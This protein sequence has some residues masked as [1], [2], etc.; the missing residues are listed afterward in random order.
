MKYT[1]PSGK[2]QH[3]PCLFLK[4]V[5]NWC[6]NLCQ[7]DFNS[8]KDKLPFKCSDQKQNRFTDILLIQP[9]NGENLKVELKG[10]MTIQLHLHLFGN[11]IKK[12]KNLLLIFYRAYML[13]ILL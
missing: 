4:V 6:P 8:I 12:Y 13:H 10:K 9:Y 1:Q 3:F 5:P 7:I 11:K 2:Y